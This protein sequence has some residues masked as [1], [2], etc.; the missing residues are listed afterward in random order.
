MPFSDEK[1]IVETGSPRFS[2]YRETC[3]FLHDALKLSEWE[4]CQAVRTGQ[5]TPLLEL[6]DTLTAAST[7]VPEPPPA[8]RLLIAETKTSI[9][10]G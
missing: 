6:R 8:I 3:R 4:G 10:L 1:C 7:E 2:A 9:C 5:P